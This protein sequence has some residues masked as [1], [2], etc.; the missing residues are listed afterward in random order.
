MNGTINM[1]DLLSGM[2]DAEQ[3]ESKSEELRRKS[4]GYEEALRVSNNLGVYFL[5]GWGTL[6]FKWQGWSN[7]G[8]KQNPKKFLDQNLGPKKTHANIPS[9][10]NFQKALNDI[11]NVVAIR[12]GP[13]HRIVFAIH[14][15]FL[16]NWLGLS[17]D[18][19]D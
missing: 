9:H 15:G 12:T 11:P 2:F 1:T 18:N 13:V 16:L 19:T 14:T 10:K 5:S 4:I 7:G 8:K 6:D 3:R 17:T